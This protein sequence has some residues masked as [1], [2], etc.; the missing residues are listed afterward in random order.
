MLRQ[1]NIYRA[2]T[3]YLCALLLGVLLAGRAYGA[4]LYAAPSGHPG[5]AGSQTD[6]LDF[7]SAV[8]PTS[9]LKPG[10]TLWLEPGV[11]S[12]PV[13][14]ITTNNGLAG[15]GFQVS[16]VGTAAAPIT[17]RGMST[18][19][20]HVTIDGGLCLIPPSTHLIITDLEITTLQPRP[21][22]PL[23]SNTYGLPVAWG[24]I[25]LYSG[26]GCAIVDCVIHGNCQGISAWQAS[27]NLTIAGCVIYNDGWETAADGS[28]DGHE[29]YSQNVAST[30]TKTLYGNIIASGLSGYSLHCYGESGHV[31]NFTVDH[32]VFLPGPGGRNSNVLIGGNLPSSGILFSNNDIYHEAVILGWY[33]PYNLDCTVVGNDDMQP[34]A[35]EMDIKNYVH[36]TLT[37]NTIVGW[38]V[39]IVR[40]PNWTPPAGQTWAMNASGNTI[41]GVDYMGFPDG[42]QPP[43]TLANGVNQ[44]YA[45]YIQAG[46]V[47][48][49]PTAPTVHLIPDKY[50]PDRAV[51]D[52]L[53]WTKVPTVS[54]DLSA[55]LHV[56]DRYQ[57]LNPFDLWGAPV[58]AG[59]YTGPI[60]LSPGEFS[61]YVVT[62]QPAPVVTLDSLA[63]QLADLAARVTALE[64]RA[65]LP[66]APVAK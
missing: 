1:S 63:A 3:L 58:A 18:D 48:S 47:G 28:G 38:G 26:D 17:I 37:D 8:S 55:L 36:T 23:S 46:N 35:D 31:E 20:S 24:G 29:V 40:A 11:Y 62:R 34:S 13:T 2:I 30:G 64:S 49:R 10:D 45:G 66:P 32:N 39:N 61:A 54:V 27:T 50:N 9:P 51:L 25:N 43:S 6:P 41:S 65:A 22:G 4:D 16:L 33:A 12:Y 60:S 15:Y 42:W 21:A 44:I 56:G 19:T 59:T 57:L 53:N 52:V 5:A 7:P 14:P